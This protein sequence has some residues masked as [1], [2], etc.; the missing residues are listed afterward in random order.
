MNRQ[1]FTR[2][3]IASLA[4]LIP[5]AAAL[6]FVSMPASSVSRAPEAPALGFKKTDPDGR[7]KGRN[8]ALISTVAPAACRASTNA[9]AFAWN[10]DP[11]SSSERLVGN[12]S[13]HFGP[14][15]SR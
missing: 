6:S 15:S 7:A 2:L 8:V 11:R 12:R 4:A 13:T 10:P 5:V 9:F 14:L 3:A 1:R